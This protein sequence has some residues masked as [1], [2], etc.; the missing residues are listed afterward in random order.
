[1]FYSSIQEVWILCRKAI[2]L[3]ILFT[4]LLLVDPQ[5]S[6]RIIFSQKMCLCM[7]NLNHKREEKRKTFCES[8]NS[9]VFLLKLGADQTLNFLWNE[10]ENIYLLIYESTY[11]G[12]PPKLSKSVEHHIEQK[13]ALNSDARLRT[14]LLNSICPKVSSMH[15]KDDNPEEHQ[16]W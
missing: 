12:E 4:C 2:P 16:S 1:M 3:F 11:F 14:S 5:H 6:F 9:I 10:I 15:P 8:V 7:K 13:D